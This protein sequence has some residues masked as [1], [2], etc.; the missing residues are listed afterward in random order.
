MY[1]KLVTPS[2]DAARSRASI[3]VAAAGSLSAISTVQVSRG[4]G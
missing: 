2:L 1:S 4:R 3:S